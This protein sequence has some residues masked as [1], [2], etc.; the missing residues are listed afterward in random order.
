MTPIGSWMKFM[1]NVLIQIAS[2]CLN[3]TT[4]GRSSL[5]SSCKAITNT[6]D[7]GNCLHIEKENW[8]LVISYEKFYQIFAEIFT[9]TVKLSLWRYFLIIQI[10]NLLWLWWL[11]SKTRSVKRKK[12]SFFF[13]KRGNLLG[14]MVHFWDNSWSC[15]FFPDKMFAISWN[16][17]LI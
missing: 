7:Q 3:L 11:C 1:L 2:S 9:A 16:N 12:M 10:W 15:V 4:L 6:S 13:N 14:K 17:Y 8:L 5:H